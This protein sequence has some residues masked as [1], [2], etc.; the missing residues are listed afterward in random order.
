MSYRLTP[1]VQPRS[2]PATFSRAFSVYRGEPPRLVVAMAAE[3]ITRL[4]IL[5]L[6]M[7]TTVSPLSMSM[8]I[9]AY[10]ARAAKAPLEPLKIERRKPGPQDVEIEILYCGICHSDVHKVN[11]D[12]GGTHFLSCRGMRLLAWSHRVGQALRD[13]KR[14]TWSG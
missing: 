3:D 13:S 8:Q 11:D 2:S 6:S 10:G 14:A 7:S 4:T 1:R 9:P 12:W 5:S